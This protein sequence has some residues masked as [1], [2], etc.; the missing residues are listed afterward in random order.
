[1]EILSLTPEEYAAEFDRYAPHIYNKVDFAELNRGKVRGLHYLSFHSRS[2]RA[3][4]ILGER[5]QGYF[6]PF[7]APFGGMTLRGRQSIEQ[8]CK[9]SGA[10]CRWLRDRGAQADITL[11]PAFYSSSVAIQGAAFGETGRLMWH[12]I[13]YHLRLDL[14]G[15]EAASRFTVH[16]RNGRNSAMRHKYSTRLLDPASPTDIARA[17]TIIEANHSALGHPL[18]MSL[19]EV[20]RTAPL[21]DSLFII[22]EMDGIDA[23]AAMINPAA[24]GIGQVIYWGDHPDA[25]QWRPMNLF[26]T[27]VIDIARDSGFSIL[28]IGPASESGLP[29][30]GLCRFKESIGC[31]PSL[32]PRYRL[33]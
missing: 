18:R 7:S 14:P 4:I 27:E 30:I 22:M 9:A 23:A 29:A 20:I 2:A 11:P 13:N 15:R 17:Y 21:T 16:G 19:D 3:G 1:M 28:D 12:D 33:E 8:V 6:S 10:L 25:R 32:K 31:I 26:A 24:D 5:E